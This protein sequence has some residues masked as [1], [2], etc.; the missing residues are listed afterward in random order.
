MNAPTADRSA[1]AEGR[2][3]APLR[4]LGVDPGTETTG[5]GVV[6]A[7]RD[8]REVRVVSF[9]DI[10]GPAKRRPLPERLATIHAGLR[11]AIERHEPHVVVVE[12]AFYSRNAHAALVLGHVRGVVLLAVSQAGCEL[13]E[14]APAEVKRAV[15]GNGAA[16]KPQ[17]QSMVQRLLALP[18]LPPADA[19]DALAIAICHA[20]RLPLLELEARM[21]A[22]Q[23]AAPRAITA[24]VRGGR[25]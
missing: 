25:P 11:A 14:Y 15:C 6:D 18:D 20:R 5:V 4:I 16:K 21:A 3:V 12:S 2:L 19:A 9:T 13:A 1:I 8:G 23:L 22:A 10:V 24:T 17:V 7:S